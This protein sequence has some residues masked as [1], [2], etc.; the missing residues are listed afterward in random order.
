MISE[1]LKVVNIDKKFNVSKE[2]IIV[3]KFNVPKENINVNYS[4]EFDKRYNRYNRYKKY[5]IDNKNNKFSAY[6]ICNNK[7][8]NRFISEYD[9]ELRYIYSNKKI[10]GVSDKKFDLF[11]LKDKD[12]IVALGY[13]CHYF[14]EYRSVFNDNIRNKFKSVYNRSKGNLKSNDIKEIKDG[15]YFVIN[16]RID[17]S[18]ENSLVYLKI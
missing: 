15:I 3:K 18:E 9:T 13:K 12:L 4:Y 1:K 10:Y 8:I 6:L 14:K 5:T 11:S 7:I 2:N 17:I 16:Q